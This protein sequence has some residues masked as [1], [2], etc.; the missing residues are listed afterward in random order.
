MPRLLSTILMAFLA[1]S[2]SAAKT[3]HNQK[4]SDIESRSLQDWS[5]ALAESRCLFDNVDGAVFCY[6]D[7]APATGADVNFSTEALDG[8]SLAGAIGDPT[9][10][11][12][13]DGNVQVRIPL[14]DLN[15]A[16]TGTTANPDSFG[17]ML[18]GV[19]STGGFEVIDQDFQVLA[20]VDAN[21]GG[22]GFQFTV[23][24]GNANATTVN[25]GGFVSDI[26]PTLLACQADSDYVCYEEGSAL[27]IAQ[28]SFLY[29]KIETQE[30]LVVIQS[31]GALSF[32]LAYPGGSSDSD[33]ITAPG[34]FTNP[35]TTVTGEGTKIVEI[36]TI[37][38]A[39][40]YA[41]A[42]AGVESASVSAL[43]LVNFAPSSTRKLLREP[44]TA[45]L[46]DSSIT[47]TASVGRVSSDLAEQP[48]KLQDQ[49]GGFAI[50]GISLASNTGTS[51]AEAILSIASNPAVLAT[52]AVMAAG[53]I[54]D[55]W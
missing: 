3:L 13:V 39:T 6:F 20:T 25:E 5:I 14:L 53:A 30:P 4:S 26:D 23:D 35:L 50:E 17:F 49:Q 29:L 33:V 31:I 36:Q 9:I 45:A 54:G 10:V 21:N 15:Q 42:G 1:K 46:S 22:N 18:T 28:G 47:I 11:S 34:V 37:L 8:F 51:G 7:C 19:M 32:N 2:A 43:G 40:F 41:L 48:R 16:L 44:S 12:N 24:S 52:G 27:A 38:P 55:F